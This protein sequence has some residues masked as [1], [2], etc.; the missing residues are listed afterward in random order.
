LK[1]RKEK[2]RDEKRREE[3][4]RK[5][6]RVGNKKDKSTRTEQGRKPRVTGTNMND[7]II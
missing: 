7:R 1:G 2:D 5:L 6:K 4:T 3:S